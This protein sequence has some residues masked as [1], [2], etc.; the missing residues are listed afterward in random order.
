MAAAPG[1]QAALAGTKPW[2]RLLSIVGFIA[3]GF[4]IVVGVLGAV[5]GTTFGDMPPGMSA[6]FLI[7]PLM[8]VLYLVPSLYLFRYASRIDDYIRGGEDVQLELALGAQ[9]SF[10]RFMGILCV[11]GFVLSVLSIMAAIAIPLVLRSAG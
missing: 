5:F 3:A 8:G 9:R 10:W 1:I 4:M 7:Y 6:V 2:V 11:V